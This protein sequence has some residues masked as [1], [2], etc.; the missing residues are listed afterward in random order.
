M[1]ASQGGK[2]VSVV[3]EKNVVDITTSVDEDTRHIVPDLADITGIHSSSI[4]NILRKRLGLCRVWPRQVDHL[5][6]DYQK[7]T[8]R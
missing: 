2:P 1:G 7:Q 6:T 4:F 8:I 3:T 5:L